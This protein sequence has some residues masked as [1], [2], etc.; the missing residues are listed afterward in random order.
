MLDGEQKRS[1]INMSTQLASQQ[2]MDIDLQSVVEAPPLNDNMLSGSFWRLSNLDGRELS[3]FVIL[4]PQG[5]IGN[6]T[7]TSVE[8][9][10]VINGRLCLMGQNGL[11]SVIFNVAQII[12][13][14]ITTLAG[15]G[16]LDGTE[17]IYVLSRT[18]HPAHPLY[19]TPASVNRKATF[20]HQAPKEGRRPNLVVLPA[21]SKSLHPHW[22]E[23]VSNVTRNW[24]LAIG[25]YGA[26]KPNI[27]APFEYLAHIPKT[28][29]FRLLYNMFYAGSPLWAYEAV[30]M[31]DD[32]LLCSG[33]DIN[34]MFH[35]FHRTGL[36][37]AQPAMKKGPECY[38]NHPLLVQQTGQDVR[39]VPFVEIMC[40]IFSPRM[41]KIAIGS[42]RDV[43]SGYGL[44]HLWPA[45]L[46]Y[47]TNRIGIIDAV[48]VAHTRP[49][50]ATYDLRTAVHEQAVVHKAY[51]HS[52]RKIPGVL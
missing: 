19:A 35:L 8:L 37:L 52:I 44:D 10:Q 29:K 28:K 51:N 32:D 50:G 49:I 14:N 25:Y 40:P 9:W 41:L 4:A 46:G 18:D 38:P 17:N 42:M 7:S 31:P 21:G 48:A 36:D 43:E 27:P 23:N 45:F 16:S 24:D 1:A 20:L 26:E 33:T 11:P 12:G 30:W 5:L 39:F 47:P 22:L 6:F 2:K 13:G 15:K 3:P 34:Q